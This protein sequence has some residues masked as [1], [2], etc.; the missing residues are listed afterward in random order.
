VTL[1]V[2]G[3][4]ITGA[5]DAGTAPTEIQDVVLTAGAHAI[6]LSPG[7][8]SATSEDSK[9][10]ALR[11]IDAQDSTLDVTA[12]GTLTASVRNRSVLPVGHTF[13]KGV[14]LLD[15]HL[16]RQGTDLKVPGRHLGLEMTRT[17]SSAGRGPKGVMGAGWAWNW[18]TS[19]AP[20]GDCGLFTVTTPAAA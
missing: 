19:L 3:E 12:P 13:V 15:G 2:E 14:D 20:S 16:V 17:Y 18:E 8:F 10:F 4:V 9:P 6:G 1:T 5:I 7:L 11:A